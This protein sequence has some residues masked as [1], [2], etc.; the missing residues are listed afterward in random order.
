MYKEHDYYQISLKVI[1]KNNHGEI[2]C[3]GGVPA[4]SY[5]GFFDLPGGRIDKNEFRTPLADIIKR[6]I[7]EEVGD[8]KYQLKESPVAVGRH[9]LL[10]SISKLPNDVH[11]LYLF[12]EATHIDGEIKI[13][14]E[15]THFEWLDINANNSPKYFKS[16][17]LEGVNM[18]L[19]NNKKFID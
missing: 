3:L 19:E 1:I 6:E 10:A 4:G 11:V 9:L 15:H 17:N 14:D 18:Y 2:L 7:K 16:A 13:S 12:F 8:I 5:E